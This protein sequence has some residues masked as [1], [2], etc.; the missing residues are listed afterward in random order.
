MSTLYPGPNHEE[1]DRDGLPVGKKP[2]ADPVASMQ[3][4]YPAQPGAYPPAPY[5]QAPLPVAPKSKIV[6]ALLFFFLGSFGIGNFYLHQNKTGVIKLVL[7]IVGFLT[8]VFIIG[9]FILGA[10]GI[11][12]FIEMILVLVGAGGYDRDGRGVPL[13]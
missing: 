1:F 9:L 8:S 5:A 6:A 12:S 3:P 7:F 2:P 4:Q 13:D 11:W 10:L